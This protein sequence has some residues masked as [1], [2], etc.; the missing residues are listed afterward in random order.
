V[1]TGT[2]TGYGGDSQ[3]KE[4]ETKMRTS[5]KTSSVRFLIVVLLTSLLLFPDTSCAEDE[6]SSPGEKYHHDSSLTWTGVLADVVVSKPEMPARYKR[7]P[8]A[9]VIKLPEPDYEGMSVEE[10]MRKRR[11]VRDYSTRP[12]TLL[13][14]SQLL[15]GAQ[16]IT[17]NAYGQPLRTSPSAGALYPFEVYVVANRIEG[18]E[19]GIYHYVVKEHELEVV[20]KGSFRGNI[21]NA[22]LRQE[23]LGDAGVTLVLSAIFD[24]TRSKY[25]ERGFRYVYMEAG[26]IAQNVCLQAVSMGLGAVTVGAFLD[27]EVNGLLGVDG[28]KEAAIY[29]LAIGNPLPES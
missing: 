1:R 24:R 15:F 12:V 25:G 21:V 16:G 9:E 5:M 6:K 29:L 3:T 8:G 28:V 2:E 19:R 4:P 14:L 22:G 10:A 27:K 20:K 11:S 13:Q 18:L 17:G 7:Y 26:H 23:A